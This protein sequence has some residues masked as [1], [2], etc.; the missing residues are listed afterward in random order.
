MSDYEIIV[1]ML[2]IEMIARLAGN[3]AYADRTKQVLV[4]FLL[5]K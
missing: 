5:A 3:Q 4:E 2:W 1:A